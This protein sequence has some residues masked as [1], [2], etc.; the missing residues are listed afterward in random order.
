MLGLEDWKQFCFTWWD[1]CWTVPTDGAR[2]NLENQEEKTYCFLSCPR[3][4]SIHLLPTG[5]NSSVSTVNSHLQFFQPSH[6]LALNHCFRHYFFQN[7]FLTALVI[8]TNTTDRYLACIFSF[9]SNLIS[10]RNLKSSH[11]ISHLYSKNS[12]WEG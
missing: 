4:P 10:V 8:I 11:P 5:D 9:F 6:C 1:H 12:R 2:G 7:H 3:V